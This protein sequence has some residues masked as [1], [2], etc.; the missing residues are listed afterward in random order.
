MRR[1]VCD[2]KRNAGSHRWCMWQAMFDLTEM[3]DGVN[4]W[5]V[6]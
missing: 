2:D 6:Y 4:V 1:L 3:T 5:A